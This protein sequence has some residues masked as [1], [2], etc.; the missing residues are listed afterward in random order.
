MFVD[1]RVFAE[2][3]YLL[4]IDLVLMIFARWQKCAT[5][6]QVRELYLVRYDEVLIMIC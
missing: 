6:Y 1:E 3:H 2:L 5:H 4:A